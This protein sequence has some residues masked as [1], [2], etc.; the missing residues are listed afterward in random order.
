[1]RILKLKKLKNKNHQSIGMMIS[2]DIR[3]WSKLLM[4]SKTV[5]PVPVKPDMASKYES[6]NEILYSLK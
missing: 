2:I 1:M 4:L 6:M 3:G 5:N